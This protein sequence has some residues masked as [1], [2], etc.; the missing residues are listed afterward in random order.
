MGFIKLNGDAICYK[1]VDQVKPFLAASTILKEASTFVAKATVLFDCKHTRKSVSDLNRSIWKY[2]MQARSVV[3]LLH[4]LEF[5]D[6]RN[7]DKGA[8]FWKNQAPSLRHITQWTR[9]P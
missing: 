2:H 3:K 7:S 8:K 4:E 9:Q 1:A 6:S 5:T